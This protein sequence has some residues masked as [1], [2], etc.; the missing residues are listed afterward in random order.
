MYKILI[1]LLILAVSY[2]PSY[3]LEYTHSDGTHISARIPQG[4]SE[5][6]K[7]T[8][9]A[10][11]RE[12][13]PQRTIDTVIKLGE[14]NHDSLNLDEFL[15]IANWEHTVTVKKLYSDKIITSILITNYNYTGGAHW[16]ESRIGMVMDTKTGKQLSLP[17]FYDTNKLTK[18]LSLVWYKQITIGL[19]KLI[20]KELTIDEKNWIHDGVTDIQQYQSF[21]I[22]PRILT[23]FGQQYQ[24]NAY[25]Y[26]MQTLIYPR[27]KLVDIAK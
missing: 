14:S 1:L 8:I 15:E 7:M 5:P 19:K 16:S 20:W 4:L 24:H 22:T 10:K 9:E 6:V 23:I 26:G 3:W 21:T 13:L 27:L 18:K 2:I 11:I 17:D 25:A 12:I